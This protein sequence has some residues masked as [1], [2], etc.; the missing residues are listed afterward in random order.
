MKCPLCHTH[1]IIRSSKY[2]S[3]EVKC[4][5]L[6]CPNPVCAHE[7]ISYQSYEVSLNAIISPPPTIP[8]DLVPFAR[9]KEAI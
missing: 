5:D 4:N 6:R 8:V 1:M 2:M 7:R 3:S 9:C